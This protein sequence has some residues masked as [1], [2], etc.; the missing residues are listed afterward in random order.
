MNLF[1]VYRNAMRTKGYALKTEKSYV[2]WVKRYVRFLSGEHPRNVGSRGVR[3]FVNYLAVE[4]HVSPGT[5][6]QALAA[7]LF[8]YKLYDIEIENVELLRAKK[9]KRLPN[10]LTNDEVFQ[11]IENLEGIYKIMG[12]L[13][14]GGGLRLNECLRLRVKDVDFY[15]RTVTLRDTKG[16][17]DRTT[18]L[19]MEVI[20]ALQLHLN[21]VR[22]LHQED[23]AN[24]LGDV[25]MPYAL[26]RK[27]P[28]GAFEWGWQYVFPAAK[29]SR[30]PRSGRIGRH[31]IYE[32]SVQRAV[33]AA[34]KKAGIA[35]PC[36]P[37]TLRHCFA[38]HL[39][40]NGTDIRTI[41]ELLGHK[42][43]ETTM[44]YTHIQGAAEVASPLDQ[45]GARLVIRRVSVK[46]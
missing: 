36:G 26:A 31:H 10:V 20:P 21:K 1:D 12:Q 46:S 16:N 44:I 27:Y 11:L 40:Q 29:L 30:E 38:T 28:R 23:L 4:K 43:L 25:E 9:D 39:L 18:C 6:N 42:K 32:T 37:H 33:K 22:A 24:G 15:N 35:R 5:Q 19:P 7:L 13:M 34:A 2:A 14:Y 41:Q 17:A 3:R 8:L 45:L